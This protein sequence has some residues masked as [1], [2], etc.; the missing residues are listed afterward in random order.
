MK[1]KIKAFDVILIIIMI[2]IAAITIY[3]FLNVLAV[4]LNDASDT[5]K[6][7]IH[8]LPRVLTLENYKEIFKNGDN[9]GT[10]LFIS[11]ARTVVGTATGVIASAMVA[12]TISRREFVF[13]KAITILFVLTMYVGGGLIPEYMLIKNI[14]LVNHFAVYILPGLISAFNVIVIR[15]FIDGLP[16]A[17]NESAMIDGANDFT[18]FVKIILPLCLPVIAT[19]ALFIA[20][21]QWNSW[22]DTYL[23]ASSNESL[24]T[25]QYELMKVMGNAT[26]NAKVDGNNVLMQAAATNPESIKMAITM[27]ATVPILLVYPFVQKYF[28]TGMTLGAVKS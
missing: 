11:I 4:S 12:Y 5:V 15:S 18:I 28:V 25:L 26:G 13:N 22:F 19:V 14:G 21:S 23:Y 17:L 1:K 9:L 3:P 24:T 10:G 8:I 7:G 27:V 6:G 2:G 20:V 16:P